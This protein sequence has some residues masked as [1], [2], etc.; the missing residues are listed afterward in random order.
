MGVLNIDGCTGLLVEVGQFD[1]NSQ[2]FQHGFIFLKW[3]RGLDFRDER[4]E[5]NTQEL[6]GTQL[7]AEEVIGLTEGACMIEGH[8]V[9]GSDG[10]E[11]VGGDQ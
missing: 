10:L 9:L 7:A 8:L 2:N 5:H 4:I 11:V 1:C 6:H 3:D